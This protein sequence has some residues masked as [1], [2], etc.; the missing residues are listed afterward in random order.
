MDLMDFYCK[1]LFEDSGIESAEKGDLIYKINGVLCKNKK[2]VIKTVFDQ[3]FMQAKGIGEDILKAL[4]MLESEFKDKELRVGLMNLSLNLP[5][6]SPEFYLT[7]WLR[8]ALQSAQE[9]AGVEPKDFI[10]FFKR[11]NR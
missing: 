7:K 8:P 2:E 4:E 5:K 9:S 11:R 6:E 1:S 10:E 3:I